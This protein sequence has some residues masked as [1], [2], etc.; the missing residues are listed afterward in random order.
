MTEQQLRD[1]LRN[2]LASA[3]LP[4]SR[5]QALLA[6]L[7]QEAPPAP[8]KGDAPMFKPGKFRTVLIAV[9]ILTLLS[10][11]AAVAAG[12]SGFV[13]FKGEPVQNGTSTTPTDD[14]LSKQMYAAISA[15]PDD[16][17]THVYP[18]GNM[19]DRGLTNG[20]TQEF[21]S[22]EEISALLPVDITLPRPPEGYTYSHGNVHFR[23]TADGAYE[24]I[25]ETITQY[26]LTIRSY[27]IPEDKQIATIANYT[28]KAEDKSY[29]TVTISL[30]YNGNPFF[31]VDNVETVLTPDI[32]GM[33]E[34]IIFVR[35]TN[36]RLIMRRRLDEPITVIDP[37]TLQDDHTPST[38]ELPTLTIILYSP[39]VPADVLLSM[40]Q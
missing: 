25:S 2:H 40:V 30:E 22:L 7:R 26:G 3:G 14:V 6:H 36:T 18:T 11:T 39:T 37:M 24:L 8:M 34:A 20:P 21:D 4:D 27:R 31:N 10:A 1:S 38:M 13:N 33:E 15:S 32:P 35:P 9:L 19:H 29:I 5:K 17:F 28:L 16:L 12:F 23:C